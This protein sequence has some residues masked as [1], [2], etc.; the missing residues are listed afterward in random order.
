MNKGGGNVRNYVNK[1]EKRYE[2]RFLTGF[3]IE[4][5][6]TFGEEYF[7]TLFGLLKVMLPFCRCS[8]SE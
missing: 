2:D 3:S 4:M 7:G 5:V 8:L 6:K 1:T